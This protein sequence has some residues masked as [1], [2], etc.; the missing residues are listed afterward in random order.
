[1]GRSVRVYARAWLVLEITGSPFLLGLVTSVIL[2][3]MLFMPFLGGVLADRV[4][5]AQ[6]LNDASE[7]RFHRPPAVGGH[8]SPQGAGGN[9]LTLTLPVQ[10]PDVV[11]PVVELFLKG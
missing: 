4:D 1:M 10:R 7:I 2:W 3:P 5:Y 9:T 6:L 11:V 8:T